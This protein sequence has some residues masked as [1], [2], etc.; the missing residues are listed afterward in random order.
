MKTRTRTIIALAAALL[1]VAIPAI[2]LSGR[3]RSVMSECPYCARERYQRWV[4]LIEVEDRIEARSGA[5]LVARLAPE[6]TS[7]TWRTVAYESRGWFGGGINTDG[8]WQGARM[9]DAIAGA[10]KAFGTEVARAYLREYH[11]ILDRGSPG[12][13]ENELVRSLESQ[14]RMGVLTVGPTAPPYPTTRAKSKSHS[15]AE[16]IT[17]LAFMVA[18][19]LVLVGVMW[20]VNWL[21]GGRR[22]S[23]PTPADDGPWWMWFF[24]PIGALFF[25][26]AVVTGIVEGR[27][28][29]TV[30]FAVFA[31]FL[32]YLCIREW[33]FGK[34]RSDP[35][36]KQADS[37]S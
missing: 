22:E 6:H 8:A 10:E 9:L 5:A 4:S 18:V 25:G 28:T 2:L 30:L 31:L 33:P 35:E 3:H 21:L 12:S 7:H 19:G 24:L 36:G 16:D 15:E 27:I 34:V 26:G 32:L 37:A 11:N 17:T 23:K 29:Y 14:V 13:E 20:G 1:V